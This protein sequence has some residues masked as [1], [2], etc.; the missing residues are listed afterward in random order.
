MSIH[1]RN[2]THDG[3]MSHIVPMVHMLSRFVDGRLH[4]VSENFLAK[5]LGTPQLS[6]QH[7]LHFVLLQRKELLEP[8]AP[9][10]EW[11]RVSPLGKQLIT[12]YHSYMSMGHKNPELRA[13]QS[14]KSGSSGEITF[15]RPVAPR[16]RLVTDALEVI[17]PYTLV[18]DPSIR[19]IEVDLDGPEE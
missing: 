4:Q 17:D 11:Y 9:T 1:A 16:V 18:P 15:Q 14:L 8:T 7:R 3:V 12:R 2:Q 10:S 6:M 5:Q 19:E 13:Y